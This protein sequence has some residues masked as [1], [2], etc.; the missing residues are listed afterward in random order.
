[1]IALGL[2]NVGSSFFLSMPITGSF[3]RSAIN[4]SSGVRTPLGGVVTGALVLMALAFLTQTFYYIPKATLAAIII[5]AMF[6]MVEYDR[7]GEIWRSKKMDV[8]PFTVTVITCLFWSLE[9]GII[10]GIFANLLFI[11]YNSARPKISINIE[12]INNEQICLVTVHE[13]L[14]YSSAEYLKAKVVKFI[15]TQNDSNIKLVIINGEAINNIDSTVALN[16]CSLKEDLTL[17]ECELICW[18][19]TVPAAGAIC[20]LHDHARNMFK[21]E[22]TLEQFVGVENIPNNSD[23]S[24]LVVNMST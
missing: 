16:V 15:T 3:T 9:Y 20:R 24:T 13:N 21:F 19:W 4:N 8:F 17:L 1:M 18:N 14:V 7:I 12:K 2:C 6:F 22:K 23:N 11:L 5:A 10:C